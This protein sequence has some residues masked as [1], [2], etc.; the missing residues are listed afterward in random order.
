[1]RTSIQGHCAGDEDVLNDRKRDIGFWISRGLTNEGVE[2]NEMKLLNKLTPNYILKE[3]F[4]KVQ[5]RLY[6]EAM[7]PRFRKNLEEHRPS[8]SEVGVQEQPD[9]SSARESQRSG[10]AK[11]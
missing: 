4:I 5:A 6:P 2:L 7:P 11:R 3:Y 1:M 10:S 8:C 9:F